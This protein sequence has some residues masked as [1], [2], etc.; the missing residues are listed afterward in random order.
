MAASNKMLAVVGDGK[1]SVNLEWVGIPQP[2]SAQVLVKV[3]AAAQNPTDWK[4]VEGVRKEGAIVG[5]D[6]AGTVEKLGTGVQSNVRKVGDRVAGFIQGAISPNGSFAQYVVADAE[7]LIAL[8]ASMSFEVGA[9][10]GIAGYTACQ[11]LYQSQEFS[12]PYNP[13]PPTDVLVWAGTTAVGQYAIQ[14]ATLSGSRVLTTCSTKNFE[15]VES[16]GAAKAFS[17]SDPETPR[18]IKEETGNKLKHVID[19]FCEKDSPKLIAECV[20]DEGGIVSNILPYEPQRKDIKNVESLV[21][22]IFGKEVGIWP[23]KASHREFG[24]KAS[25]LLSSLLADGK[26]KPSKINVFPKGL[27]SVGDGFEYMKSGK[28]SAE[29]ITYRV[30]DTPELKL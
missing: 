11:M 15:F 9:Q 23:A 4:T 19:C 5:C 28:V 2:G 24:I 14:L 1:G 7:I 22:V 12:S 18:K 21:Y 29:K 30:A 13:G 20:G 6:F 10:F 26:L 27:A 8:P 16:L 17:Y 3:E 25:K